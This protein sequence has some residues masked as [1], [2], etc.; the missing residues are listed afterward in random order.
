MQVDAS[1]CKSELTV[2]LTIKSPVGR[3][4]R[5]GSLESVIYNHWTG[6][7]DW[8]GELTLK[9]TLYASSEIQMPIGL[10]D[11]PQNSLLLAQ[12]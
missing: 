2:K 4:V 11:A 7:V 10:H 8:T 5:G 9:I 12:V 6:L 3:G 1:R